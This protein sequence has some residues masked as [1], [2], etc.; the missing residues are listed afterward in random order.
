MERLDAGGVPLFYAQHDGP[1]EIALG[2]RAGIA[3]ELPV[4]R[5]LTHAVEHLTLFAVGRRDH[6]A[7][8]FVDL[9]RT[10]FFATGTMEEATA[11]VHDVV[12]A[13]GALPLDRLE[14]ELRVLRTEAGDDPASL[15]ERELA[16]R[17]GTL[18]P[19]VGLLKELALRDAAPETVERWRTERFTA[20]NAA[21]WFRGPEPPRLELALPEG[22]R[23]GAPM[24]EP[25]ESVTL[26]AFSAEGTG[27]VS[28]SMR[29]HRTWASTL[30]LGVAAE[31]LHE[32]LRLEAG[33][34][35]GV[36][37]SYL[38]LS[39]DVAHAALGADCLDEHAEHAAAE[40]LAI[41]DDLAE[42]GPTPDELAAE[43]SRRDRADR[44]D[45][46]RDL[47]RLDAAMTNTLLGAPVLDHAELLA[48]RDGVTPQ[49][50]AATMREQL[51][52]AIVIGPYGTRPP[53]PGLAI[54]DPAQPPVEGREF[55]PTARRASERVTIGP[56]GVTLGGIDSGPVTVRRRPGSFAVEG[57]AAWM[58]A[59]RD[60]AYIELFCDHLRDGEEARRL[61][62]EL[63]GDG[64]RA[65]PDD[66]PAEV[67]A[68]M[69]AVEIDKPSM[70]SGELAALPE[71]LQS[72]ERLLSMIRAN[73]GLRA[74][75]LALTDRRLLFLFTG[76]FKKELSEWPVEEIQRVTVPNRLIEKRIR[77]FF[78]RHGNDL[79]SGDVEFESVLP[80]PRADGFSRAIGEAADARRAQ[81]TGTER[82]ASAGAM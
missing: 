40:L 68:R 31:R 23:R 24:L 76:R 66:G 36:G 21:M 81:P 11:F 27:G 16:R 65:A 48:E 6:P 74:G 52:T 10:V 20:Q 38:P 80:R 53:R 69:T 47:G 28:V 39:A 50:I 45:A 34:S 30:A 58:L 79:V 32:R 60:G 22:S 61:L 17:Y 14:T 73:R 46:D 12:R 1:C 13:L 82:S 29:A 56:D 42:H 44:D 54:H 75:L 72:G 15:V 3:D 2:F 51:A 62:D 71:V 4:E 33:V 41:L 43:C 25:L 78:D 70:V 77:V 59:D 8:G 26:P 57:A 35:Y 9:I 7:N 5:G 55:R 63:F 67:V 19:G 18:G 37:G 49:D 64:Y